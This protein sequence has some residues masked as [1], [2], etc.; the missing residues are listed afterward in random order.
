MTTPAASAAAFIRFPAMF[1][2]AGVFALLHPAARIGWRDFSVHWSTVIGIGALWALYEWRAR[3]HRP[4]GAGG[5][6]GASAGAQ[7]GG[8]QVGQRAAL[9][10]GRFVLFL[11]RQ[12]RLRDLQRRGRGLARPGALQHGDGPSP[13]AHRPASDHARERHADVVAAPLP[14]PG[15]AAALL[16]GPDAVRVPDEH[17]D[18]H[19][20][21][22]RGAC[23]P[24]ALPGLQR[25]AAPLGDHAPRG[26]ADRRAHHVGAGRTVLLP[27][28]VRRVL[29]VV[30]ERRRRSRRRAGRRG[31]DRA[32]TAAAPAPERLLALALF[33]GL[34]VAGMLLVNDPGSWSAIYPPLGH[35]PGPGR[36]PAAPPF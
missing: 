22:L 5:T 11:P 18:V 29:P 2:A 4:G 20:R 9:T 16:S 23:G 30:P 21:D 33:P 10:G 34:T 17:P 13:R 26:P 12:G 35:A 31:G 19:R 14:A 6:G 32:V 8:G 7:P 15:V 25:G 24:R 1:A 27:R 28:D 3:V 36:A